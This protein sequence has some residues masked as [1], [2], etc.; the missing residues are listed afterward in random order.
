[1][2]GVTL[3]HL[4]VALHVAA[5]SLWLGH[6][7]FWSL[8]SGPALK[9]LQPPETA[10]KLRTLS[11][12]RGGL[13]WPAM[14]VLT[15]T[16]LY[17]LQWRGLSLGGLVS[18]EL[19]AT[20]TGRALAAKLVLMVGMIGFQIVFAHRPAPRAIYFNMAAALLVLGA[21]AVLAGL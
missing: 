8:F 14:A 1:V 7:F 5:A 15:V 17:Q 18:G 21:S 19:L 10:Q 16:G 13:G 12:W 3:Y 9:K 2:G 20:P 11:L 4:S 6:M